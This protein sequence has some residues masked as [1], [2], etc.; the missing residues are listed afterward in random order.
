MIG[1]LIYLYIMLKKQAK[2]NDKPKDHRDWDQVKRNHDQ[3]KKNKTK[4]DFSDTR[5]V[6]GWEEI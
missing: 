1:A 3:F 6:R 2:E 5:E 4:H